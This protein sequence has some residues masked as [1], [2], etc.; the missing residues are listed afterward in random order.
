MFNTELKRHYRTQLG[1]NQL[2]FITV[3]D[4]KKITNLTSEH[5]ARRENIRSNP[6]HLLFRYGVLKERLTCIPFCSYKL[7]KLGRREA[8]DGQATSLVV[9]ATQKCSLGSHIRIGMR[10]TFTLFQIEFETSQIPTPSVVY[11][12]KRA[13]W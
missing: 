10:H 6:H 3:N 4:M 13:L 7:A 2:I 5:V 9:L 1:L 12:R 11:A 8:S